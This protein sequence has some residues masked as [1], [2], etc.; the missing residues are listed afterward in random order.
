MHWGSK[1][2]S[3]PGFLPGTRQE[4]TEWDTVLGG[5]QSLGSQRVGHDRACT[6]SH[7]MV[8]AAIC[9]PG[10]PTA[11]IP[12]AGCVCVYSRLIIHSFL[13]TPTIKIYLE[14]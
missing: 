8:M 3:T 7:W 5:I 12:Y 13:F 14:H 2:Q 11:E 4:W 6:C 10:L 1:W 9:D